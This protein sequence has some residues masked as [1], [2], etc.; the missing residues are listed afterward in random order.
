MSDTISQQEI[1]AEIDFLLYEH[2][3]SLMAARDPNMG[4]VVEKDVSYNI[5]VIHGIR[6][7]ATQ[8]LRDKSYAPKPGSETT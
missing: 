2:G 4:E 3:T 8:I 6:F 7:A 1:K 5:G